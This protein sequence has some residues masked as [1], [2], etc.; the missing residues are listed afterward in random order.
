MLPSYIRTV[1]LN[2]TMV[3]RWPDDSLTHDT[4]IY[5]P[6]KRF[7]Y[8]PLKIQVRVIPPPQ[9]KADAREEAFMFSS[10]S[11]LKGSQYLRGEIHSQYT[12]QL[13]SKMKFS[14]LAIAG[15]ALAAGVEGF[16]TTSFSAVRKV[17]LHSF[18]IDK[19]AG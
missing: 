18:C 19:M 1:P 13:I 7:C 8:F 6:F 11:I 16:S 9:I 12:N 17:S 5:L 2:L 14:M 4:H 3:G 10:Y 15:A